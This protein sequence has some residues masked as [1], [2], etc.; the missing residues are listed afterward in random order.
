MLL[1]APEVDAV[2]VLFVTPVVTDASDVARAILSAAQGSPK[3]VATCFMGRRGVP[4][5]V[6]SLRAGRF[7]SYA[8]PSPRRPP[9]RGRRALRRVARGARGP[10]GV[11]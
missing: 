7:P 1:G 11:V 10:R 5:A 9:S 8:F 2:L 4:E 6:R 3:T